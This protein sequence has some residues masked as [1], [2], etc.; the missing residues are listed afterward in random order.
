MIRPTR[1][2][3]A[4][5]STFP[6]A[7]LVY[8]DKTLDKPFEEL[9]LSRIEIANNNRASSNRSGGTRAS[10]PETQATRLP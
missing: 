10:S 7:R 5:S 9:H 6:I 8:I 1:H 3:D 2:A 4:F